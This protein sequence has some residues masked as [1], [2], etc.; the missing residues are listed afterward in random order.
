[1]TTGRPWPWSQCRRIDLLV[2]RGPEGR[3]FWID[4]RGV[5]YNSRGFDGGRA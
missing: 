3:G 1:V 5:A 4:Q 2:V